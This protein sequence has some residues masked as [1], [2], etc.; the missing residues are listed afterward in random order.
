MIKRF[1]KQPIVVEAIQWD[2][3]DEIFKEITV[4]ANCKVEKLET[5]SLKIDTLEGVMEAK[6]GDWIIKGVSGEIYPCKQD[7]FYKTY[8]EV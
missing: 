2:G 1:V 8:K 3:S 5:G 6:H 4:W 7:I